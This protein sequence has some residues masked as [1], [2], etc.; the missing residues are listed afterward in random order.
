MSEDLREASRAVALIGR[1]LERACADLTLAQY[2]VLAMVSSGDARA[3]KIAERL[4]VAKPTVTA[5]VDGLVDRGYLRREAVPGDRRAVSIVVTDAG[6]GRLR[7]AEDAMSAR[8]EHLIGAVSDR[9]AFVR[10]LA[11]IEASMR[12]EFQAKLDAAVAARR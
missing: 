4:A 9:T 6:R 3:S 8:L 7:E 5:V 1:T 11:E 2:R 12:A 10:G